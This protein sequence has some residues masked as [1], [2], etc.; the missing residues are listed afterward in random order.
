MATITY[1]IVLLLYMMPRVTAM[2]PE[3]RLQA[4]QVKAS[5]NS[6]RLPKTAGP[7]SY[8]VYL[9]PDFESFTFE[10]DVKIRVQVFED[11]DTITLHSNRQTISNITVTNNNEVIL[12]TSEANI[13]SEKH[14]L[15]ISSESKFLKGTEYTIN[16]AFTGILSEDMN[17]FY[18]SS[19]TIGNE[20]RWLAATQF[21]STHARSA[22]PCF[23]EPEFKAKFKITIDTPPDYHS[24]SNMPTPAASEPDESGWRKYEF[25]ETEL[26]STYLVAFIVS[27]FESLKSNA[28]YSFSAWARPNAIENA[29]YSQ[30][31]G[32][33]LVNFYE[34][35]TGIEYKFPKIDQV[36]VPDFAAG[37]M[38]NWGLIT[39]RETGL[40]Y[41]DGIS[42][43]SNKKSTALVIAHELAHMWF[44]NLVTLQWWDYT[45]LNEG[46]ARLFQYLSTDTVE[47]EWRLMEQFV[48]DQQHTVFANDALL[49]AQPLTSESN[50]PAEIS[51]KFG[52]ITYS[53]GGSVLRMLRHILTPE[54]FQKGVQRYLTTHSWHNTVPEDLFNALEEQRIEDNINTHHPVHHFFEPWTI[55]PGYPV[56]KVVR[57]NGKISVTQERFLLKDN[58]NSELKWFVPLTW[59]RESEAPEGFQSTEPKEWLHPTDTP[60][61]LN[62]EISPEEWIIF[63]NQETGYYRVNYDSESWRLISDGLHANHDSIHPVNRAQLLDD[64]LNLAR[65]GKLDYSTA[66]QVTV[67]L[68]H[69]HDYIPWTA[70]LNAFSFLD[71][72]LTNDQG[73]TDFKD[74]VLSQLQH[75]YE[76]LGFQEQDSDNQVTLLFRVSVLT[77]ACRLGL[78]ECID[79]AVSMFKQYQENTENKIPANLRRLV[80]CTALEHEGEEE[81]NFLWER[82]QESIITTEQV[83]ILSALGCT[84]NEELLKQYLEKSI[85]SNSGIRKQDA[86][87]VF[88]SVYSNPD[89]VATAFDFL[90]N[91]FNEIA[92]NYGGMNAVANSI[93][94]IAGRL[95]TVEQ[96]N[97]L[98][99]F[100]NANSEALGSAAESG[101]NAVEAAKADVEWTSKHKNGILTW[102]RNRQNSGD[103]SANIVINITVIT[104]AF[105]V[106]LLT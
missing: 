22:F 5:D 16:I 45:W 10:G 25:A 18:R 105:L 34:N 93:T 73:H 100:I 87:S 9:K 47:T 90:K 54:T 55:Q 53:K 26:M 62:I 33:P 63:N 8:E 58:E 41:Y 29:E 1:M 36:A 61:E 98:E 99:T 95:T 39:Y 104:T 23:D 102:L 60:T 86:A 43:E 27:D 3:G 44:G 24:L 81:W 13:D 4:T 21:E 68:H 75:V 56:I 49:S 76:T 12:S 50:T 78:Q 82:Y 35:Y 28:P 64:A 101:R 6:Y 67:Y 83:T 30:T 46:F 97:D 88:S 32:P 91:N 71:R 19:Y 20:I 48:V 40:L 66:L 31:I 51:A 2:M 37:A 59:T 103:G 38:E 42:T 74:Y 7:I 92:N 96:V 106:A 77:W 70:A 65:A 11:T 79:T 57:E 94:G 69:D 89:G 72:R 17:G 80:F 15:V 84:K 14:F 52:T 85:N